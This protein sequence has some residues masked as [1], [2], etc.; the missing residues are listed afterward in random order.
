MSGMTKKK[1]T[2]TIF[3]V[4]LALLILSAVAGYHSVRNLLTLLPADSYEDKGIYTFSPRQVLPVQVKNKNAVGRNRR[5]NPTRTV[6]MVCYRDTGGGG[7]QWKEEAAARSLG[8]KIVDAG[9][10]VERRVLIIPANRSY[11]TVEPDQTAESYTAGLRKRYLAVLSLAG[12][13]VLLYAAA[14]CVTGFRRKM[15]KGKGQEDY[16]GTA[17][18]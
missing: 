3:T 12:S 13:Y 10:T 14:W 16:A 4:G 11:I 17:G 9:T 15:Q 5:M 8:E 1:F 18:G 7:Y 2:S 6:Y